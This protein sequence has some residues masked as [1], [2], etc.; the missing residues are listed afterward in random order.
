MHLCVGKEWGMIE[1]FGWTGLVISFLYMVYH[2]YMHAYHDQVYAYIRKKYGDDAEQ[3]KFPSKADHA[4][5]ARRFSLY[6]IF[7]A[8]ILIVLNLFR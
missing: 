2:R 5:D 3:M 1:L 7:F 8:G 4:K 6:T